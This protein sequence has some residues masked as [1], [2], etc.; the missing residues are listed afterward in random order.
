MKPLATVISCAL[1]ASA[2]AE[3]TE[4]AASAVQTP[5]APAA[6][7]ARK[8]PPLSG[9]IKIDYQRRLASAAR[10]AVAADALATSANVRVNRD[11]SVNPQNE[12][13]IAVSPTNA[14]RLFASSNDYRNDTPRCGAYAST[15]GG[16][17]WHDVGGGVVPAN[18]TTFSGDP[19]VAFGPDGTAYLACLGVSPGPTNDTFKTKIFVVG[20]NLSG[21]T[22]AGTVFQSSNDV[23]GAGGFL[24][25]KPYLGVDTRSDSPHRGRLYV[26]WT[27]FRF[28][29]ND[30]VEAPV[31][32]S[33]SDNGGHTWSAPVR[34][35]PS[36]LNFSSGA[37]PVVGQQG[38][39]YVAYENFNTPTIN[40]NQVLVS[41]STDGGQSFFAPH[42][43]GDVF[44]ICPR[45]N[46]NFECSLD[47]SSFR[48]NSFPSIA[49]NDH[50]ALFVTWADYRTGNADIL[51]A[52]SF[53]HASTWRA[54][55]RVD[56]DRTRRD[57]FF[58][59]VD[60][61]SNGAVQV[62]YYDRRRDP[63]NY[64]IEVFLST[65]HDLGASFNS[66]RVTSGPSDPGIQF[67]GTFIGD[68]INL[69]SASR[70]HPV[71]TDTRHLI[72]GQRQQDIFTA[73]LPTGGTAPA[74]V[75][76]R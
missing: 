5:A 63:N 50:D 68:Y 32:I 39:V 66:V 25:D 61:A 35:A 9:I 17:T 65:S 13:T 24:N 37:V 52:R 4:P 45:F 10:V 70:A 62:A 15:D 48:V 29:G 16:A 67:G 30:F 19:S 55:V 1:I 73:S 43:A 18:G 2:C 58:P 28:S 14:N 27:R 69:A 56:D 20:S 74:L 23:P 41:K 12:P 54:P 51:L 40:L 34:V 6:A 71:W 60:I 49:V 11:A 72:Q 44:D 57:Q 26:A 75:A 59:W 3:P 47:N 38:T 64:L 7:A 46:Q 31:V 8:V 33:H 21:L 36:S 42:K 22:V 53:T 76:G